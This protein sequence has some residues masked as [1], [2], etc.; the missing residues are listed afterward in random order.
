[1]LTGINPVPE[2]PPQAWIVDKQLSFSQERSTAFSIES[3]SKGLVDMESVWCI[4]FE[5]RIKLGI[6]P[7]DSINRQWINFF[8]QTITNN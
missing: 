6:S 4:S 5:A 8:L 7:I 1:M 2:F 3:Q